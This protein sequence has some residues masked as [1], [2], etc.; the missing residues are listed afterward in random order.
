M[1]PNFTTARM[2][3]DY[4]D[5][6]YKPQ[7]GRSARLVASDYKLAKESAGWK[8]SISSVWDQIEVKKVQITDGIT[9]VLKIGEVYPARVIVDLK[10]IPA[11]DVGVEMVITEN[12]KD[13]A[14]EL[15]ECL[16]F[17]VESAEGSV[18][19]YKLDLHLMD[20]G[21]FSYAIRMYPKHPELP[22]RQDFNYL[23]WV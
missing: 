19:T 5:R 20:A 4:Q 6:Y 11:E 23:K 21:A 2:I 18:I 3:R 14:P 16:Q 9:N 10:G 17:E 12:G 8:Y 22:H 7:A 1:A 15:I 13:S